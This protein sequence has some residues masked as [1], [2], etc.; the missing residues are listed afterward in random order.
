MDIGYACLSVLVQQCSPAKTVTAKRAGELTD[1]ETRIELCRR[2][3]RANLE[4]VRRLLWHNICHGL[5]LYR[6][7][8]QVV[9]LATHP[10]LEEWDWQAD[11][12]E[13]FALVSEIMHAHGLR[14]SSHPDHFTVI[15]SPRTEVVQAA[16]RDLEYHAALLSALG[17]GAEARMVIHVGGQQGGKPAGLARF[18]RA[19]RELPPAVQM[20]LCVENDD[21]LYHTTDVLNLCT[22]IGAPMVLDIHHHQVNPGT[23]SLAELLPAIFATW[24]PGE[25]P[26]VHVS[27]PR[28]DTA[29]KAHADFVEPEPVRVLLAAAGGHDFDIMVEAKRK[30]EAALRLAADLGLE[31]PRLVPVT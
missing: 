12:A 24:P 10:L 23:A 15:S 13:E 8:P 20:R 21:T 5:R 4:N 11:L 27:S 25:K 2:T 17:Y 29:P 18:A 22:E 6:V 9:P 3:A 30:D 1:Q 28:S 31:L 19:Y 26:K 7:P 16:V 14:I